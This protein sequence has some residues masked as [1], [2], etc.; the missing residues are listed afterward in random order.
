M[1]LASI[2]WYEYKHFVSGG[3][4]EFTIES[5]KPLQSEVLVGFPSGK[6]KGGG[7]EKQNLEKVG[8]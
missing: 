2:K 1:F 3:W 8:L 6:I 7:G 4:D 5:W